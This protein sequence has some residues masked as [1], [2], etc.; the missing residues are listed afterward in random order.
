MCLTDIYRL[1]IHSLM[2]GSFDLACEL[3][4]PWTKELY[5]CMLTLYG[6]C[7]NTDAGGYAAE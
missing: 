5:L 2:V 7:R 3:L 4:P 1:E 6:G